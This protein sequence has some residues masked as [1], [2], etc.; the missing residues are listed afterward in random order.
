MWSGRSIGTIELRPLAYDRHLGG[1]IYDPGV[2]GVLLWQHLFWF[3]GH[4]EV[5]IIALPFF[6]IVT[7]PRPRRRRAVGR[8]FGRRR[9]AIR[10]AGFDHWTIFKP[11]FHMENYLLPS[12]RDYMFPDLPQG[13]LVTAASPQTVM[14][15]I[16]SDDF[17]AA[18]AAAAPE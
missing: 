6:G 5:Y 16:C 8:C 11:A 18:V 3:F 12:K 9:S 14:A 1:H 10:Q 17:G 7:E 13:K 15:L 2:G 4:P